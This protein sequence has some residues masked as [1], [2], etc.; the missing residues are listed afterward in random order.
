MKTGKLVTAVLVVIMITASC[1]HRGNRIITDNGRDRLEINYNGEIKFTDDE[2]AIKSISPNGYLKYKRND[3]KFEIHA[4]AKG[5][6]KLEMSDNGRKL[7]EAD[8]DGKLFLAEAIQ[9]MISVGFDAKARMERIYK[10]GGSRALLTE[11]GKIDSD[12][13]KSMYLGFLLDM[14]TLQPVEIAETAHVIASKIGSDF[15]KAKLLKKFSPEQ[16]KDSAT[17]KAWFEATKSIGSDFD[18]SNALKNILNYPLTA[19]QLDEAL[20]VTTTFG[21]DFEKSNILKII[22]N[23]ALI[24]DKLS[25]T[26]NVTNSLGS[27]F[28]KAN[29]LRMVIDHELYENQNFEN[30]LGSIDHIGS[31]FEKS[32]LLK[33]LIG[34][35]LKSDEQW[36]KMINETRQI[37]S[38]FDRSNLLV[39]IARQM[40]K[41]ESIKT[42]YL[43]VAKSIQ[44]ETD[45]GRAIKAMD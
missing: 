42:V 9:N 39:E 45:L 25:E 5:D 40:P 17:V 33:L 22:L 32:N 27:D 8:P 16:L 10:K 44:S 19:A 20:M 2:T 1:H 18:K 4:N 28:E 3:K 14:D 6:F 38:D 36:I 30:L 13:A 35:G 15:E 23:Q 7:N 37:A 11:A 34:N 41:S 21:S 29:V 12:F 24:N 31:D 43:E 26:L